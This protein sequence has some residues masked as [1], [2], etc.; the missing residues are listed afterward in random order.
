MEIDPQGGVWLP[1][2][3]EPKIFSLVFMQPLVENFLFHELPEI[4]SKPTREAT[5]HIDYPCL[6]CEF[7]PQ[8]KEDAREQMTLSLIPLLSKKAATWI[9]AMFQSPST[10]SS[11]I[12]DLEDLVRDHDHMTPIKRSAFRKIMKVDS[13]GKSLMVSSYREQRVKVTIIA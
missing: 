9:K 11:E 8:C 6:Q 3:D 7:L 12:C 5:W 2:H 13:H 1:N 10:N 4:L